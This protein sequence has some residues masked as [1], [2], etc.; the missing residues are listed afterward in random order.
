MGVVC[1]NYLAHASGFVEAPEWQVVEPCCCCSA[2]AGVVVDF[3]AA[4]ELAGIVVVVVAAAAVV[5]V[6]VGVQVLA[7]SVVVHQTFHSRTKEGCYQKSRMAAGEVLHPL[8]N[9]Y[10]DLESS[11]EST[12]GDPCY[13]L[14]VLS[15]KL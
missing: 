1:H 13:N 2:A 8:E 5:A 9:L 12:W 11:W 15:Q 3:A 6:V 7:D 10:F 4:A 14:V